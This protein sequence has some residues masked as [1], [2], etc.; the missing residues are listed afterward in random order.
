MTHVLQM[1]TCF[2]FFVMLACHC[3]A[4]WVILLMSLFRGNIVVFLCFLFPVCTCFF[5]VFHCHCFGEFAPTLPPQIDTTGYGFCLFLLFF[6]GV[7]CVMIFD[8]FWRPKWR[9]KIRFVGTYSAH[10]A[11]RCPNDAQVAPEGS[12]MMPKDSPDYPKWFP[13]RPK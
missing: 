8:A 6:L 3:V 7:A 4:F 12:K 10:G 9:P 2:S 13:N 1:M 11:P 5:D